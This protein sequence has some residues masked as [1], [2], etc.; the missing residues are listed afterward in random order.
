MSARSHDWRD[1]ADPR[2][3][4]WVSANAGA[5]KTHTL[6]NRVTRLLLDGAHP[7]KILCL[8]FTKAAAAEMQDRLFKQLGEWS[9]LDSETLKLK[10]AEIGGGTPDAS[11]LRKARRLFAQALETP[12]GLKIQTLHAFCERLLSRFP[13][14]AGVPPAFRVLDDQ[15]A[16]EMI[17]NARTEVLQQAGSGDAALAA[18]A[19]NL[20]THAGEQ[21]VLEILRSALGADR[22]KLDSF[23]AG[24]P[25]SEN[26]IEEALARVH[27][28]A[29]GDTVNSIA[30]TFCADLRVEEVRLRE[31]IAWLASGSKTDQTLAQRLT[32]LVENKFDAGGFDDFAL[33]FLTKTNEIRKKLVTDKLAVLRPD[34]V[35]Y[36]VDLAANFYDAKQRCL[37]ARAAALAHSAVVLASAARRIY[38]RDKKLRG[39]LDYSDLIVETVTLLERGDVAAWVLYKLDEGL[40]HILIDEAQD[41]SPEQWR[42]VRKLT[43]EFFAGYGAKDGK[44]RTVFAVGDEKQSIF[45]FQGADPAA[46]GENREH[47]TDYAARNLT[48]LQEVDL[49]TSRRSTHEILDFVDA[50]FRNPAARDGLTSD[51]HIIAHK[52]HRESAKGRVEFWP[53][54]ETPDREEPDYWMLP[55]DVP[56]PNSAVRKLANEIALRIRGWTDGKTKLPGHDKPITPGD[57]MI[58]MPRR[59]PF[60][61]EIIKRLK[62]LKVPVAGADRIRLTDQIAIMD[63]IALGRFALLPEDDLNLAALLRSP[64]I[65]F[66]DEDLFDLANPRQGGLWSELI[67]RRGDRAVFTSAHQLLSTMLAHADFMPPHEFYAQVLIAH[68]G[69]QKLL[70]RLGPEAADAIDE[71]LSLALSYEALN[72]PSLEGFLHWIERG[73]AEIKRDMDRGRNEVRVMTVHG[74]KGLEADI[75]IL[76]DTTRPPDKPG[77][78]PNLLFT[79]NGAFYPVS[80]TE[81]PAVVEEVKEA[82]HREALR[83]YRRLLY[84]ALTRAKDRLCIC[85][86]ATSK[87]KLNENSWYSLARRAAEELGVEIVSGEQTIRVIGEEDTQQI[88]D[89][90]GTTLPSQ[91][92]PAWALT[93][94]KTE[95]VRARLLR[96]SDAAGLEEP[97]A[98]SP[99]GDKGAARFRR[100]ILVHALLARLPEIAAERRRDIAL[101]FLA[102]NDVA[103]DEAEKLATETLAVLSDPTFAASFATGSR[104]EVAIVADLPELGEG[105]RLN[106]RIDRLAVTDTEVLAID[107]KTNRPPP[108][109]P[110]DVSTLYLAQMALYRAAL[111]KVFP[112][113]RIACALLWTEGP[114]LMRLPE[115]LLDAE[116]AR[117]RAR[118]DSLPPGS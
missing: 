31:T 83:E 48:D 6:A 15:T 76:P 18:A 38:T 64:L 106:G 69:R 97:A 52:A 46:F 29:P 45:S 93:L 85:G 81:A 95:P 65:G 100:G 107:F 47:F 80:D 71:F 24:L 39:V 117:I 79:K 55:L 28:V 82:A 12:G 50:V 118:L 14:E 90:T 88:V 108:A 74:A 92:L 87:N 44:I 37:S 70:A 11:D 77:R 111:A 53:L 40:D 10:I 68:R 57:I 101:G 78:R 5:G 94:P 91:P 19:A 99:L 16:R 84:V 35:Q 56:S 30:E 25:Q 109:R 9:M 116:I 112:D 3:S 4:A 51:E 60:A 7:A 43:D 59:E 23:L 49:A 103:S 96:P 36:I 22:G 66:S 113:K 26:A 72:T 98:I 2:R 102:A 63:L 1:A 42:I 34:L 54:A 110:Q 105:A 13:L 32:A 8:T 73:D 21:S 114:R 75:V 61:S 115:A 27:G 86:F 41:T 62:E 17:A 67:A 58:L 89:D 104:A 33:A 20:A